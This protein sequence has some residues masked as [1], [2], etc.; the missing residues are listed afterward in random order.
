MPSFW[1][2]V[3]GWWDIRDLPNVLLVHFA[4]LKADLPGEICRIAAFLDI[5]I[6]AARLPAINEHCGIE[7]MRA[8]A[9]AFERLKHRFKGGGATFINKGTNE[10]WRDVLSPA[11]IAKC[12]AIAAERLTPDCASWLATGTLPN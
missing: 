7:H 4:R 1:E 9:A 2:N 6:D 5:A 10:R 11:E 8:Q 12:D 3:Q